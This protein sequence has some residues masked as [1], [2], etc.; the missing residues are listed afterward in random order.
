MTEG[1]PAFAGT[2]EVVA[3]TTKL[4]T[5]LGDSGGSGDV[6][7]EHGDGHGADA[8]GDGGDGGGDLLDGF[9]IY[10]SDESVASFSCGVVD[11]IDS[12]VDD[13]GAG[14]D[15]VGGDGV[16]PTGCGDQDVGGLG[17]GWEVV[18]FG[19]A[20]GDGSVGALAL[21]GEHRGERHADESGASDDDD[22]FAGGVGAAAHEQL[23][24]AVRRGG[25]EAL[26]ALQDASLIC[27]MQA[28]DVFERID[29]VEQ[30]VG[31]DAFGQGQLEDDAVHVGVGV[32]QLDAVAD[33]A[34]GDQRVGIGVDAVDDDFDAGF[35]SGALLAAHVGGGGGIVA[36]EQDGQMREQA[37]EDHVVDLAGE[38]LSDAGRNRGA[39]DDG[40]GHRDSVCQTVG[41]T[42]VV[43]SACLVT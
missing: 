18:G 25:Q 41:W 14:L 10:V 42:L 28:V 19:V 2:T 30:G 16:G 39:V 43:S 38:R 22:V 13:G 26:A 29:A 40:G 37:I 35:L 17:D 24:D 20:D 12:D 36:D 15:H 6:V 34:L 4:L 9:E 33:A 5:L 8:S 32:E 21:L 23:L 7:E 1:V 11:S 3:G 31:I 27:G